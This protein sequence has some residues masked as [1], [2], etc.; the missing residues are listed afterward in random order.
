MSSEEKAAAATKAG[1]D[2][3]LIYPRGPFDRD[4]Q[5]ALAEQF[6]AAVGKNGA[7]VIYDPV[8]GDYAEPALRSIAG[9]GTTRTPLAPDT[10]LSPAVTSLTGTVRTRPRPVRMPR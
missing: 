2:E 9:S 7:D 1:A 5:K 10:T 6:K 4:G 3:T 8:G